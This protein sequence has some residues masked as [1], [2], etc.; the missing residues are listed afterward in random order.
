MGSD[1]GDLGLLAVQKHGVEGRDGA[2]ASNEIE[3]LARRLRTVV[4][5]RV[6]DQLLDYGAV[7]RLAHRI[8]KQVGLRGRASWDD[9]SAA[10]EEA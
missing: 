9:L 7:G 6:G 3:H 8:P 1:A 2:H 10:V 5:T 4:K